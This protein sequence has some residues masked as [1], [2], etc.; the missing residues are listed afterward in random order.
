MSKLTK[1]Y[2]ESK[3]LKDVVLNIND[4]IG[5]WVKTSGI[6]DDWVSELVNHQNKTAS[7]LTGSLGV[8]DEDY[9]L[10]KYLDFSKLSKAIN[11]FKK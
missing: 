10:S 4:P 1:E 6:M 9:N 7:S 2:L 3:G 5:E 8:G 11:K